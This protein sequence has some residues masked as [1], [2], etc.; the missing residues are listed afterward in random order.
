MYVK[1]VVG[2]AKAYCS[3]VGA[4]P[5]ITKQTGEIGEIIR[6]LGHEYGTTTGRPRDTG[7]L[8]LVHLKE[9]VMLSSVTEIVL[10]HIDTIGE[11]GLRVDGGILVCFAY[12][13][14]NGEPPIQ[15]V[16]LNIERYLPLY[17]R[18]EGW[19]I[20]DNAKTYEDLPEACRKYIEYIENYIGVPVTYIG[21]GPEDKDYIKHEHSVH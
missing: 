7:W 20:P 4:G 15:H 10:N 11:I 14:Q 9:A 18:F 19:R 21:I 8:D 13:E 12:A 17:E 2:V 3:R 5:F 6:K 1:K 16:P